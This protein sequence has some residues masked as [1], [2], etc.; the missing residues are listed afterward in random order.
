M[1]KYRL[2]GV[3]TSIYLHAY[4]HILYVSAYLHAC[5]HTYAYTYT[6]TY[7][8]CIIHVCMLEC[9]YVHTHLCMYGFLG[10]WVYMWID[11]CMF[12]YKHLWIL[13]KVCVELQDY[14]SWCWKLP[15]QSKYR[16]GRGITAGSGAI[17]RYT[18]PIRLVCALSFMYQS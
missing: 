12:G 9:I 8:A 3:L 15:Q 10:V 4:L 1:H 5:T 11:I 16:K 18:H 14:S 13:R 17:W 6:C 2:C 7:R